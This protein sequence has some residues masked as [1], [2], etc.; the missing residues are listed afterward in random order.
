MI[1]LFVSD[2]DG[3]LSEPYRSM[4]LERLA[5][6]SEWVRLGGG[7]SSHPYVPAFSLCSGRPLPYVEC[8]TQLLGIQAPV[9]FESGGGMFNPVTA[10]VRWNPKITADV[11][12]QL[13]EVSAWMIADCLDGTSMVFDYAKRTQ[14]GLI[15]PLHA[16]IARTIPRVEAFVA[17]QAFSLKVQ[18]T[19]LSIDV[20]PVGMT[21]EF[22]MQW[23]AEELGINVDAIA[24]IGDSISDIA[25][26]EIVRASFAPSNAADPVKSTVHTV[27]SAHVQGVL[28]ALEACISFN[29]A[30]LDP[31][32]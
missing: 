26:L 20:I 11:R 4:D 6:L 16:E 2:I 15:G 32:S 13:D 14:A 29:Q 1:Q 9:L 17:Q 8:I 28:D 10:E 23:L 30:E 3:C 24:Y 21:K 18:P 27:T 12:A 7:L 5:R 19:H 22:G 31:A 25:A